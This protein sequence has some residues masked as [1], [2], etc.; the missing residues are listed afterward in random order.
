MIDKVITEKEEVVI[1]MTFE[2]KK[3]I[4]L[5]FGLSETLTDHYLQYL[6]ILGLLFKVHI[7][8]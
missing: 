5:R 6:R 4:L 3:E 7:T 8:A 2:E 1:E